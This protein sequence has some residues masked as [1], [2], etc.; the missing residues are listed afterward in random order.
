VFEIEKDLEEITLHK[1]YK[2]ADAKSRK[3]MFSAALQ[4]L[5]VQ[6]TL[7]NNEEIDNKRQKT[8]NNVVRNLCVDFTT[9]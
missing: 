2:Q 6:K 4:L 7:R 9:G 1:I 5:S 3:K 8:L